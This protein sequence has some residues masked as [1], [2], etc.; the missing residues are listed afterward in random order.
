MVQGRR[1]RRRDQL[2]EIDT[3]V[4]WNSVEALLHPLR[5]GGMGR[6]SYAPRMLFKALLLQRWY[7][8]SDEA[9]EDALC[10]RLGTRLL[11]LEVLH[12]VL[13]TFEF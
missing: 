2:S 7:N 5:Q 3:L 8:L 9:L 12:C 1:S 6:P 11:C 4:D 10:D 13:F